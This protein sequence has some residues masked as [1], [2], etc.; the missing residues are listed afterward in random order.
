LFNKRVRPVQFADDV[1][2]DQTAHAQV[3]GG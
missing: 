3:G 1:F 2:H